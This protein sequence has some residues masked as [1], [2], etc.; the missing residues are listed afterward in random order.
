M[1]CLE[2]ARV[3]YRLSCHAPAGIGQAAEHNPAAANPMAAVDNPA[4]GNR[5]DLETGTGMILP[6]QLAHHIRCTMSVRKQQVRRSCRKY[7][8]VPRILS[9]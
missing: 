1:K 6:S 8:S 3:Y 9:L 2:K 7:T 4:A 5:I